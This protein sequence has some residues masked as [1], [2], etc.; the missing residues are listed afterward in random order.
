[1]SIKLPFSDMTSL[2]PKD[3][4]QHERYK[5]LIGGIIPRPI[6]FVST[7]N[8]SGQNNLAPFSFFN[9]VGS[10][11][12]A[13]VFSVARKSDGSKKDTLINIEQTGEWVVN[14]SHDW[15]AEAVHQT[16]ADYPYG[17]DEMAKVGLTSLPSKKVQSLRVRESALQM[18]CQLLELVEVG[19]GD[20]GSATLV[21][22]E[23]VMFHV[24]SD[25]YHHGRIDPQKMQPIA[26]LGGLSYSRLGEIFDAKPAE[27]KP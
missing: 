24:A 2:D 3:L 22:G 7:R 20:K 10:N 27:I 1:M 18:E 15:I 8:L 17:V 4:E 9:G 19:R 6:A 11:P 21:I 14:S 16:S 26:R 5:F 25:F 12:P 13:L 23:I